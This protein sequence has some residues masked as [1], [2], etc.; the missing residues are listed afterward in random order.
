VE[1]LIV[2]PLLFISCIEGSEGYVA[3]NICVETDCE[4]CMQFKCRVSSLFLVSRSTYTLWENSYIT[5]LY[6][7]R[8][9][10]RVFWRERESV[11]S[12]LLYVVFAKKQRWTYSP[13]L[14]SRE[15][16]RVARE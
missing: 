10:R 5:I 13:P 11:M 1:I 4:Y 2:G 16:E 6:V 12:A 9:I 15:R 7:Y 3:L 14:Y 8:A